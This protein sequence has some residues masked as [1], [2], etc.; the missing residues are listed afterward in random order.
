L[1]SLELCTELLRPV[2]RAARA[3][4][5]GRPLAAVL[6][7]PAHFSAHRR[8]ALAEAARRAGFAKAS[9]VNTTSAAAL[10]LGHGK[11][12]ARKRVLLYD[13][14]G[15]GFDASVVELT[16]DDV[17]V[18]AAA[19]ISLGGFD[20]DQRIAEE[21]LAAFS[22][23]DRARAQR[24]PGALERLR[25]AAEGA[26]VALSAHPS[27]DV[28]LWLE[29]GEPIRATVTRAAVERRV[30]ELI[31]RT[32]EVTA[33][34]LKAAGLSPTSLDEVVVLGSQSRSPLVTA[35]LAEALGRPARLDAET[36]GLAS[37]GAAILGNAL[38]LAELGK[39]GANLQ[40]VLTVPIGIGSKGGRVHRVLDVNTRLPA[41]KAFSVQAKGGE[42][43][44]LAVF[45]GFGDDA[46]A[47]EYVGSA[48]ATLDKSG[49]LTFVFSVSSE[50]R[51]T[52]SA[53][54]ALGKRL[55]VAF[56]PT[57]ASDEMKSALWAQ[58]PD[59]GSPPPTP[60]PAGLWKGLRKLFGR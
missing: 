6:S 19:G 52:V 57:D 2:H 1:S 55:A 38:S 10:A 54:D 9:V 27:T 4:T 23:D 53:K 36:G 34:A 21:L 8:D 56:D 59:F 49:E 32:L 40:E 20:L 11:K 18:V 26:K 45:Q 12:L 7:V 22:V 25:R 42:P 33:A 3:A 35:R 15:G 37:I 48:H 44:G 47:N 60:Q 31:D 30:A 28:E 41:E 50:G 13:L 17:E 5:E 58:A 39:R 51:L 43:S 46:E 29:S 14:G 16:G 24:G